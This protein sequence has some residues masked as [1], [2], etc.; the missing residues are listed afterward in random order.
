M[1]LNNRVFDFG[2]YL[3]CIYMTMQFVIKNL[4]LKQI[5]TECEYVF[6]KHSI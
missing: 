2:L 3:Y 5:C 6:Y 1:S 4:K